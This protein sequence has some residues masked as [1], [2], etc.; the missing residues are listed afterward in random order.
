MLL[1]P[2]SSIE[3][4]TVTLSAAASDLITVLLISCHKGAAY[5]SV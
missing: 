2:K 5:G 3:N 4:E 1:N